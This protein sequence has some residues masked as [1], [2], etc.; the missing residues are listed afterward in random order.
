MQDQLEWNIRDLIPEQFTV[1]AR[2]SLIPTWLYKTV[3]SMVAAIFNCQS[4]QTQNCE[5]RCETIYI[6]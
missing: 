5:G 4:D 6:Y 2:V 3:A 1:K